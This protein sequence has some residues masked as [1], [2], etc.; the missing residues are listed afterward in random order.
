MAPLQRCGE[1]SAQYFFYLKPNRSQVTFPK[2]FFLTGF[3]FKATTPTFCRLLLMPVLDAGASPASRNRGSKIKIRGA[4]VSPK[5]EGF[6]W[7]KS[8]IFRPEAGDLQNKKKR[9]AEI[10]RLFL[11]EIANFNVFS[12]QRHQLLLPRKILWGEKR[13]SGGHCPSPAGDAPD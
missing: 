9:S 10:Q 8:Q 4:K 3:L 2:V 5:C 7:P 11:A 1:L 12:T 13:K 6:F